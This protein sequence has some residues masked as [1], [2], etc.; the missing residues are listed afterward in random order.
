MEGLA[1]TR[2]VREERAGGAKGKERRR[3]L[4]I[5]RGRWGLTLEERKVT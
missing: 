3:D 1:G 2:G 4:R 5:E